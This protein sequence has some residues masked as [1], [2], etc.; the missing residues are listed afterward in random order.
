[1]ATIKTTAFAKRMGVSR[2]T[3]AAWLKKGLV[4][5]AYQVAP[6]HGYLIPEEA[7]VVMKARRGALQPTD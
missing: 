4:P 7:V 6:G 1:M 2:Y 3:A 5:G